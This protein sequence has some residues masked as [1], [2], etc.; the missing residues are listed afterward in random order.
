MVDILV[1]KICWKDRLT[2]LRAIDVNAKIARGATCPNKDVE[3]WIENADVKKFKPQ[4]ANQCDNC[5]LCGLKPTE[6]DFEY[7]DDNG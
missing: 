6:N 5:S 2:G 3:I 4:A 7:V 1:K